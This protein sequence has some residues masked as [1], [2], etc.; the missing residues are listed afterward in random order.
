[1][2]RFFLVGIIVLLGMLVFGRARGVEPAAAP[3]RA[4]APAPLAARVVQQPAISPPRPASAAP[5]SGTPTI[6]LLARLESRRRLTQAASSTYFDSLFTD[7]DSVLRR[8]TGSTPLVVAVLPDSGR[9]D[10]G[11]LEA[12]RRALVVWEETGV[13]IRFTLATDSAGANIRIGSIPRFEGDRAGETH[14]EWTSD[15]AIHAARIT[16][17]RSDAKGRPVPGP[18][19]LVVAIHEIGHALGLGH[20]PSP[21]DVMYPT[22]R[23]TRLSSRDRATLTLLYELPLGSLRE[24]SAP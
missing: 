10:P 24:T 22:P 15:G 9:L 18:A 4:P 3:G 8:W 6:D 2:T 1:M 16:L 12:V 13:G 17:S 14:L 21:E 20:S 23:A 11:M 5:R 19:A 7:T